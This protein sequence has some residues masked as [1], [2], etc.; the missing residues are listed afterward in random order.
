MASPPAF[1][2]A[3]ASVR[4][5]RFVRVQSETSRFA[6]RLCCAFFALA[7]IL[8]FCSDSSAKKNPPA[9]PL[10]LNTATVKEL[11]QLPGIGPT[12]AKAIV[13]FRAKG[14]HFR[15]VTD[16]LVVRGISDAKLKKM[17]P[18]ITVGPPPK[19]SP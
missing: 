3:L 16:L 14:G 1:N 9:H 4:E 18:Y 11:E 15:R 10:D 2:E 13:D 12:T 17:R 6:S 19:K 5:I 8:S 7:V